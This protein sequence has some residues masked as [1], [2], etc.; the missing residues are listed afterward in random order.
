MA[1]PRCNPVALVTKRDFS[2]HAEFL[3]ALADPHRLAIVAT[4]AAN[5]H[6]VCVCDLTCG[7]PIG[8]PSVSHHL[9]ILRTAKL[10]ESERRGTWAY[11]SLTRGVRE[12]LAGLLDDVLPKGRLKRAS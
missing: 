9:A 2:E 6:P 5:P 7:L 12:R 3:K 10:V 8:Q 4:L 11:Y 1:T